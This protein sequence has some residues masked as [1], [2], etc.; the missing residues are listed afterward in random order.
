MGI[1]HIPYDNFSTI[2]PL[3]PNF[4][5]IKWD[6][7]HVNIQEFI[8]TFTPRNEIDQSDQYTNE[9]TNIYIYLILILTLI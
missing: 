3:H 6:T 2:V 8:T 1:L 9:T 4:N 5:P 7:T